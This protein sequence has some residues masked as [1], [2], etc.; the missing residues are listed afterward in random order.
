MMQQRMPVAITLAAALLL[1]MALTSGAQLPTAGAAS[2]ISDDAVT[3][4]TR[5]D[6][7]LR[8]AA[9]WETSSSTGTTSFLV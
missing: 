5:G 3:V 9:L 8:V 4:E 2:I 1:S 6:S 7:F